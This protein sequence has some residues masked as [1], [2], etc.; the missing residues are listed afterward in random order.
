ME[1]PN[2][3]AALSLIIWF[4]MFI[5]CFRMAQ[6]AGFG[7]KMAILLSCPGL[8]FFMLFIFAYKKWPNAPYR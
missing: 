1:Q 3:L 7:W 2:P 6:K 5:P 4:L 8:H